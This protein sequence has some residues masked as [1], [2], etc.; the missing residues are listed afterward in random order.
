[1]LTK[2]QLQ[3]AEQKN[4]IVN[5]YLG[6]KADDDDA[7]KL[8]TIVPVAHAALLRGVCPSRGAISYGLALI[9]NSIVEELTAEGITYYTPDNADRLTA[10]FYERCK[11][12]GRTASKSTD[13]T[14]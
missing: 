12:R 2:E 10:I 6:L 11:P 13:P 4:Q 5:P 8:A 9:I 1:M 3:L 7:C 14:A